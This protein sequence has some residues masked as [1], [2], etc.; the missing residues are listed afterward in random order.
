MKKCFKY[1]TLLLVIILVLLSGCGKGKQD[2]DIKDASETDTFNHKGGILKVGMPA[3][4]S[5]VYSSI[6]KF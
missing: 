4:P 3:A 6:F 2:V 1:L 5:G